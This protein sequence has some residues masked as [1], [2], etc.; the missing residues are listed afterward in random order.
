ML[1]D[2][3][4][5]LFNSKYTI[6]EVRE[7]TVRNAKDV[8]AFGFD[9][10][11]TYMFSSLDTP[12]GPL[13]EKSLYFAK[14]LTPSEVHEHTGFKYS[15]MNVGMF[16]F[17]AKQ[18]AGFLPGSFPNILSEKALK[19]G[20]LPSLTVIGTDVDPFFWIARKYAAQVGE[21][22]PA[23]LYTSLVPSLDPGLS[24]GKMS[25][26][27]TS[28]AIFLSDSSATAKKK[29]VQQLEAVESS[30]KLASITKDIVINYLRYFQESN[31]EFEGFRNAADKNEVDKAELVNVLVQVMSSY[32]EAFA[33]K[34]GKI[35]DDTLR[36][37]MVPRQIPWPR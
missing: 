17:F 22:T 23:F 19:E 1:T 25:A 11:K 13:Y 6:E 5:F 16:N 31:T 36:N 37:Y 26:S 32:L 18:S 21:T 2:D 10:E 30:A 8:L 35:T 29:L 3:S 33:V 7:F 4:K 20:G 24:A 34:R 14:L 15:E 27:I 9:L 12:N 28:S